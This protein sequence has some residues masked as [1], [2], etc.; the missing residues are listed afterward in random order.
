MCF[1]NSERGFLSREVFTPI[2]S[3]PSELI[4][5]MHLENCKKNARNVHS[6]LLMEEIPSPPEMYKK[7]L[8]KSWDK[9]TSGAGSLNHQQCACDSHLQVLGSG[10]PK[11][12]QKKIISICRCCLEVKCCYQL[13][14]TVFSISSS[15]MMIFT[16]NPLEN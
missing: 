13:R 16:F 6:P 3:E 10:L 8:L 5:T 14:L 4:N 2:S 12:I 9:H 11:K 1:R 7:P 15:E